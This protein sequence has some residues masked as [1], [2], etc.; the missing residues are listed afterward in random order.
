MSVRADET[1]CKDLIQFMWCIITEDTDS[2][3]ARQPQTDR[4]ILLHLS[5]EFL[6]E[7]F[8]HNLLKMHG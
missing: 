6:L 4:N 8:P 1:V 7:R 3:S 2:S 5:W